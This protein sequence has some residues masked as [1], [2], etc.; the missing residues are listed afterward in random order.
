MSHYFEDD[1]TLKN[2]DYIVTFSIFDREISVFTNNGMFS[3]NKLDRGSYFFIKEV[4]KMKPTGEIL[5]YGC[6]NGVIGLTLNLF[7]QE[8]GVT[9]CDINPRC[10]QATKKNLDKYKL[11]G[12]IVHS[13]DLHTLNPAS[14]DMIL[15]NPPISCG[16]E[17]IYKMYELAKFLLKDDGRFLIVIRKDKGMLSHKAYLESIFKTVT[18]LS[19][20]KGYYILEMKKV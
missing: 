4:L 17:Q 3:K 9:Y 8:L 15:L 5:D 1:Q 20:E 16:K 6:G 12:K 2:Q 14:F 18:I 19:K 11:N 7:F 13:L 10:L